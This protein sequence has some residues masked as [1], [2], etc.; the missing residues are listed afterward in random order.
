MLFSICSDTEL[1]AFVTC[2]IP[3]RYSLNRFRAT[4]IGLVIFRISEVIYVFY[5]IM[6]VGP[7]LAYF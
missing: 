3:W 5:G 4:M 6:T 2:F 1:S 7:T